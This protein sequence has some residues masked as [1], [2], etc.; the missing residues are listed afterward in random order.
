MSDQPPQDNA[1]TMETEQPHLEQSRE[2]GVIELRTDRKSIIELSSTTDSESC[3]AYFTRKIE[4]LSNLE[5]EVTT[6]AATTSNLAKASESETTA[7]TPG[8]NQLLQEPEIVDAIPQVTFLD[9]PEPSSRPP[10]ITQTESGRLVDSGPECLGTDSA[11]AGRCPMDYRYQTDDD[12]RLDLDFETASQARSTLA[13]ALRSPAKTTTIA[14]QGGSSNESSDFIAPVELGPTPLSGTSRAII[15]QCFKEVNP[16]CLDPGH[17]VVAF[18]QDQITSILRIVADESA[19]ASFEMI[20]SVVQRA[21]KLN[22]SSNKPTATRARA[23]SS[24]GP[25]TDTD[26]SGYVTTYGPRELDCSP[27]IVS[28]AESQR[29]LQS[30]ISLPSPPVF[31]GMGRPDPTS[32][33]GSPIGSSPGSQTL[34]TI[35]KE[36]MKEK[37]QTG[38]SS[39][40]RTKSR[41]PPK[42]RRRI[43]RIMR[44]EYFDTMPWTRVFVSGPVDP[45][46]NRHKIYCQI[47]K[48]NVSIRS[49]GPK[50]ILRH[51]ATDRYLREDQRWRY[52]HLTIEDPLTKR[53]RYQVRGRDG[54]ILTNYQLQLE[55]PQFINCELVDI[56]DKLPFYEEAMAGS[57][58]MSSSP[59]NLAKTQISILAYFLALS[60]DIQVLRTMWQQIGVVVNH[61]ALFSDVDWST[62]R[63]S[64]S[65]LVWIDRPVV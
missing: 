36:A 6:A 29:D 55:L 64:V 32:N 40:T 38:K 46:W 61:Q 22:L 51:Y 49:K 12:S 30:S 8:P 47:C 24:S 63:L 34:A 27:G 65:S 23:R 14:C 11:S 52:E 17:P 50:E 31:A 13:D 1:R 35:K 44:E 59:Q 39:S 28:D 3:E 58:Y 21:S 7:V 33:Q 60:G 48:C 54:K 4:S 43:G 19:R 41:G 15:K 57:S 9:D 20:N 18:N 26:I 10:G 62:T 42:P 37:K 53:P 25:D 5:E 56:G 45:R 2:P 16:I